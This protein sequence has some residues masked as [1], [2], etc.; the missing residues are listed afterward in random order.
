MR[1]RATAVLIV[2]AVLAGCGSGAKSN[3]EATKTPA[4]VIQDMLTATRD[5][6]A[7][8]F[9]GK[10]VTESGPI[11]VDIRIVRGR[12]GKGSMAESGLSFELIRLGDKMYIRGSDAFYKKFAGQAGAQL[13]HGKWLQF[14]TSD[15][16]MASITPFTEIDTFFG[17]NTSQHGKLRN[18]GETSFHGQK[19]VAIKDTT[20]GGTLYVAA[21]GTPYPVGIASSGAESGAILFDDWNA[22]AA[23]SA[24]KNAVDISKLRR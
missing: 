12:G 17:G 8:H 14:R 7:V 19:A 1:V 22:S 10:V 15:A 11:T 2:V 23:I 4:Q 20:Q 18:D 21:T 13:F 9:S 3:G 16:D 24:P 5:A 6:K